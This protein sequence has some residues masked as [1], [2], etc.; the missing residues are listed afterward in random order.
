MSDSEPQHG[1]DAVRSRL[2]EAAR[3]LMGQR[4][5]S[6][7]TVAGLAAAAGYSR[8]TFYHHFADKRT[9]IAQACEPELVEINRQA[10]IAEGR[11]RPWA[12]PLLSST[13]K[14]LTD[15]LE[16]DPAVKRE[17]MADFLLG[18]VDE[19]GYEAVSVFELVREAGIS[20]PDFYGY[21]SGKEECFALGCAKLIARLRQRLAQEPSQAAGGSGSEEAFAALGRAFAAEPVA[22]RIL[23]REREHLPEHP[24]AD[25]CLAWRGS[26]DE[27]IRGHVEAALA[28]GEVGGAERVP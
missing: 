18:R 14:L 7:I 4:E 3:E 15:A 26:L 21:F 19:V 5:Y 2:L 16:G 10:Q 22:V 6:E 12:G 20:K 28:P 1:T 13:A 9:C 11:G 24:P 27:L 23:T 8:T 17:Q 25:P